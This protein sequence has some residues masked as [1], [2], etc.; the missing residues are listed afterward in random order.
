MVYTFNKYLLSIHSELD[1]KMLRYSCNV[2]HSPPWEC[3][4]A[5]LTLKRPTVERECK[6]AVVSDEQT[7]PRK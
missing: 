1:P 4:K 5:W 6:A 7:R 3:V 2:D